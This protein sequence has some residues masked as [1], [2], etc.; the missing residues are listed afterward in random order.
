MCYV[1]MQ[2]VTLPW[3]YVNLRHS[4]RE[5][6]ASALAHAN[7]PRATEVSSESRWILFIHK[8]FIFIS[9]TPQLMNCW[10]VGDVRTPV[11]F[12]RNRSHWCASGIHRY[13]TQTCFTVYIKDF[14]WHLRLRRRCTVYFR[15]M[16]PRCYLD[17]LSER[18]IVF[19]IYCTACYTPTALF[20]LLFITKINT[21]WTWLKQKYFI[22]HRSLRSLRHWR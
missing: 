2:M 19:L 15:P 9:L 4:T 11:K 13:H 17:T 7:V 18:N 5:L 6:H 21:Y 20:L 12:H 3:L 10:T 14:Q 22:L 1:I 8:I 16:I